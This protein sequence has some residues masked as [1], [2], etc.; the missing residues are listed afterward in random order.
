M[1]SAEGTAAGDPVGTTA[2]D[3]HE[4]HWFTEPT[5]PAKPIYVAWL[6]IA[7]LVFFIALLGPAI[8]GVGIKVQSLVHAGAIDANGATAAAGVLAGVGAIFATIANVVFGRV[9][10][11]T[12]SKWGR[13]RIWIVL[14][15]IIMTVGLAMMAWAP[16]LMMASAAWAVAQ[17]GA[18]M[19]LAPFIATVADQ[20]PRFQRGQITASLGIAQNVGILGG[21]YVSEWFATNLFIMFVAPSIL[22]IGAMIV[23][24][25]VLPDK[26]LP[27]KPPKA[28]LRDWLETFWVSPV[29]HPDYAWPGGRGS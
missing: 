19:A 9:S 26:V 29:K 20:V 12:T 6:L 22:A 24:A 15:T 23:F 2:T 25:F 28:D 8:V 5:E 16:S 4:H 14:G 3:P 10:D 18:N 13:R 7:Q 27:V 17:L 11:R 1:S 21:V